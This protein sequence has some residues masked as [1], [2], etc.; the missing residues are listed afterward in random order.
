MNAK[1][2]LSAPKCPKTTILPNIILTNN[3][4]DISRL[5]V[6]SFQNFLVLSI[7]SLNQLPRQTALF[8][9]FHQKYNTCFQ[10]L[11]KLMD[12]CEP[13]LFSQILISAF[14]YKTVHVTNHNA[15]IFKLYIPQLII[16]LFNC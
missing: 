15:I 2:S 1:L 9:F 12:M 6:L 7:A 10:N 13:L 14:I 8:F 3:S 5:Y 16:K 4:V 11:F